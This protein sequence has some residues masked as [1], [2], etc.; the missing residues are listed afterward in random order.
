MDQEIHIFSMIQHPNLVRYYGMVISSVECSHWE[1]A[2]ISGM[3]A[4]VG[5]SHQWDALISRMK[6]L[7]AA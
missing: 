3:L 7:D 2:L 1:N 4:S 6:A 5:C